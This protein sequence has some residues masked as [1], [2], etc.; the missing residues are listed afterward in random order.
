MIKSRVLLASALFV[1]AAGSAHAGLTVTPA[2]TSDYDFRGVTQTENKAAFQLGTTYGF[3]SGAYA[4][5]W[6]SNVKFGNPPGTNLELDLA[7]GYTFG[8]AKEGV[9]WDIGGVYYTYF[10]G[11]SPSDLNYL[12]VYAGATKGWFNGKV[13]YSPDFGGKATTG[14]TPAWYLSTTGTFPLPAEFSLVTHAGYS[15]GDYWDKYGKSYLDYSVGVAKTFGS[16]TL[17]VSYVDGSDLPG[18][19]RNQPFSTASK[20]VATISTTLPWAS[21]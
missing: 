19:S 16:I 2:V 10:G 9:A 7:G 3:E 6:A 15:F 8:D 21:E 12:E 14:N 13:F 17:N 1:A 20:V 5:L 18:A 4:G 11:T